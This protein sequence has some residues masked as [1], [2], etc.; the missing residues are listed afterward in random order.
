MHSTSSS[1]GSVVGG[2]GSCSNSTDLQL[3]PEPGSRS[4]SNRGSTA[5]VVIQARGLSEQCF[6]VGPARSGLHDLGEQLFLVAKGARWRAVS[7]WWFR[8]LLQ[9]LRGAWLG[10]GC[11]ISCGIACMKAKNC[12]LSLYLGQGRQSLVTSMS[13]TFEVWL[14]TVYSTNLRSQGLWRKPDYGRASLLSS[15]RFWIGLL[16]VRDLR[17]PLRNSSHSDTADLTASAMVVQ[18]LAKF[19][20]EGLQGC[21]SFRLQGWE[22]RVG[23]QLFRVLSFLELV[24]TTGQAC[25]SKPQKHAHLQVLNGL[26]YK[27]GS[28]GIL[29][30]SLAPL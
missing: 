30:Q 12:I 1:G 25:P 13:T 7:C 5:T 22:F 17:K 27:L 9:C 18:E 14:C 11:L 24:G 28:S 6:K 16:L 29:G 23:V 19:E 10:A 3:L 4:A 20:G 15:E 26:W 8:K 21:N 2:S